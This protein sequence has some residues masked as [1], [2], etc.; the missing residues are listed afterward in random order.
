MWKEI[1]SKV[2]TFSVYVCICACAHALCLCAHAHRYCLQSPNPSFPIPLDSMGA[3]SVLNLSH[4]PACCFTRTLTHAGYRVRLHY[5]LRKWK[6]N[7][8]SGSYRG[9]KWKKNKKQKQ[10]TTTTR[11]RIQNSRV[12]VFNIIDILK[13]MDHMVS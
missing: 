10:T 7:E 12:H 13:S 1:A 5:K 3:I 8:L 6:Q 11:I 2:K 4:S 9:R